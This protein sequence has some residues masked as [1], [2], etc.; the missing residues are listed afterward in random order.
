A[1]LLGTSTIGQNFS[2]T[3]GGTGISQS[4][5]T[6]LTIG[7]TSTT[8]LGVS[9]SNG[10][11][12]LGN[13]GNNLGTS[14]L[15]TNGTPTDIRDINLDNN[16]TAATVPSFSGL[17]SLRNLT[18]TFESNSMTFTSGIT[19]HNG[20][21]FNLFDTSNTANKDIDFGTGFNFIAGANTV[22][23]TN[24]TVTGGSINATSSHGSILGSATTTLQSG[25]ATLNDT[26]GA[27]GGTDT[28]TSGSITLSV[29]SGNVSTSL[30]LIFGNAL[31][32]GTG[33]STNNVTS[34]GYG[35][36]QSS[37]IALPSIT[38]GTATF[39]GTNITA[40]SINTITSGSLSFT[41]T[42]GNITGSSLQTGNVSISG[43]LPNNTTTQLASGSI[44]LNA[45]AASG[46]IGIGFGGN[47]GL[48]T[49]N[50]TNTTGTATGVT[51]NA[52]NLTLT[53]AGEID[54]GLGFPIQ[55]QLGGATGAG[56]Q[57]NGTLSIIT[58]GASGNAWINA[59]SPVNLGLS[60][61]SQFFNL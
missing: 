54:D 42:N 31:L 2:A 24:Q 56:T 33:N 12:I 37:S 13:A 30:G 44:T 51:M 38:T 16:N 47:P 4:G 52:G 11:I 20:G 59:S 25:A 8:T 15:F 19:L 17:G 39:A 6:T 40:N 55:I 27:T 3:A 58:T 49:G 21:S 35:L 23:G 26:V 50:A 60:N 45:G 5:G 34:G 61:I 41:S 10:D 36:S 18:L 29:P 28:V 7:N 22:T 1:L 32:S 53:S 9:A 14:I 48:A 46:F 57:N 43:T